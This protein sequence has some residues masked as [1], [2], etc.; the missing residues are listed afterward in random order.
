MLDRLQ[1]VGLI[2]S[3][4]HEGR[5]SQHMNQRFNFVIVA[6]AGLGRVS[7]AG[8]EMLWTEGETVELSWKNLL[9]KCAT[10]PMIEYA[11]SQGYRLRKRRAIVGPGQP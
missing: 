4:N 6:P 2:S 5:M 3:N 8:Y 7:N 1:A 11:V 9:G 10:P